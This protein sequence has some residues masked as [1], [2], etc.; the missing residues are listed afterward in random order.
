MSTTDAPPAAAPAPASSSR[1]VAAFVAG[2]VAIAVTSAV[3]FA[4]DQPD[5]ALGAITGGSFVLLLLIGAR[6]RSTRRPATAGTASRVGAGVPDE[7]DKS[8]VTGALSLVGAVSFL[9][10][11]AGLT[12]VMAGLD[13]AAVLTFMI[14][15]LALTFVVSFVALERRS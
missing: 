15:A 2:T 14:L 9:L 4:L 6:W 11:S 8:I 13:A 12:C 1:F 7:R 10:A 5:T 3:F